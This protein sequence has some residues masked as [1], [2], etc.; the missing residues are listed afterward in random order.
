MSDG[1]V[2]V[3]V[4][5]CMPAW[6]QYVYLCEGVHASRQHPQGMMTVTSNILQMAM[7]FIAVRLV[8]PTFNGRNE[9]IT[10]EMEQICTK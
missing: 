2:R 6:G 8:G 9:L 1:S 5:G 7:R 10:D 4:Q 3:R